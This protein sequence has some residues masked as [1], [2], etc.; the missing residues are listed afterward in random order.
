MKLTKSQYNILAEI[1]KDS[2][3]ILFG[4]FAAEMIFSRESFTSSSIIIGFILY[5]ITVILTL[6]FKRKTTPMD[7]FIIFS[8][9]IVLILTA[10][11]FWATWQDKRHSK[12][13]NTPTTKV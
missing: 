7:N 6:Y 10:I 11:A 8:S 1:A 13:E 4:G 12:Q 5:V 9:G 2:N 3:T